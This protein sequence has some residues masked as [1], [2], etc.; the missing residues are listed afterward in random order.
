MTNDEIA[1]ALSEIQRIQSLYDTSIA[2]V[3]GRVHPIR[4]VM[5]LWLSVRD[6]LFYCEE[7]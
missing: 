4:R 7:G 5:G 2:R 1:I 3:P 6:R